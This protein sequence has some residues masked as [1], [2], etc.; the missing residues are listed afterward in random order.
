M[1]AFP[2]LFFRGVAH[3]E[4][5]PL[6]GEGLAG[7]RVVEV[8]RD[9]RVLDR[10]DLRVADLAFAVQ[11]RHH[12]P[13][14]EQVLAQDALHLEG[15]LRDVETALGIIG[16]VGLLRADLEAESVSGLLARELRL[17]LREEHV[18]ALD[19]VQ[20]LSLRGAVHDHAVHAGG[21]AQDDHFVVLDLHIVSLF[22][23]TW[24]VPSRP[25]APPS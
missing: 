5:R 8:D 13:G 4:D 14:H 18:E 24:I 6:E 15:R 20:R 2:E 10:D 12:T 21:V 22:F 3:G 25:A 19:I 7:H 9:G 17:E 23:H 1:Q 11:H 16:A